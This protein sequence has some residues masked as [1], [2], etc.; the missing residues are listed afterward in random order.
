MLTTNTRLWNDDDPHYIGDNPLA[1]SG[2]A[3]APGIGAKVSAS[4]DVNASECD[5][6]LLAEDI[7][8]LDLMSAELVVLSACE[9]GLGMVI[10]GEGVYGLR[11]AILIA[12]ARTVIS[13]LWS[14]DDEATSALMS[15][16]FAGR[17]SNIPEM[18]QTVQIE[19]LQKA[20]ANGALD[21]PFKWAPFVVTGAWDWR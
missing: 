10:S 11:R 19:Q 16:F 17:G 20:R 18:L 9:T 2:L 21:D 12:G 14:V 13:T 3:L 4:G 15:Q 1:L 5:G 8:S 7:A 6:L